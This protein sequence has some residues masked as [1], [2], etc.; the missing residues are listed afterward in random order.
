MIVFIFRAD[1]GVSHK[2]INACNIQW[3]VIYNCP[4]QMQQEQVV[5][6]IV[7]KAFSKLIWSQPTPARRVDLF[8]PSEKG[9]K[10]RVT[11]S[12]KSIL[13]QCTFLKGKNLCQKN[14]PSV[15]YIIP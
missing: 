7:L 4:K 11:G 10:G 14:I 5:K 8:A 15:H 2:N 9:N 1:P 3:F 6:K 13:V 12:Q